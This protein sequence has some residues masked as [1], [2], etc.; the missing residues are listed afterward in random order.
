[1]TNETR[2]LFQTLLYSLFICKHSELPKDK[3]VSVN[4]YDTDH[5]GNCARILH[6]I[7]SGFLNI[8]KVKANIPVQSIYGMKAKEYH[9]FKGLMF[10]AWE[11]F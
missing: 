2:R 6:F 4:L 11:F 3:R 8:T 9:E 1:M 7:S 10:P 5:F